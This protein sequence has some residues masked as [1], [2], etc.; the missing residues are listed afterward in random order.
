MF[1]IRFS[2]IAAT[3]VGPL[4]SGMLLLN[5]AAGQVITFCPGGTTLGGDCWDAGAEFHHQ[6]PEHGASD[7]G[8]PINST[9]N[10]LPGNQWEYGFRPQNIFNP[11][12]GGVNNVANHAWKVDMEPTMFQYFP[13]MDERGAD[14]LD[15][16]VGTFR[17]PDL[18]LASD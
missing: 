2:A 12:D 14:V 7:Q 18:G 1:S 4:L 17:P 5:P 11:A 16:P 15:G 8:S 13:F 6:G 10:P 3:C 9:L